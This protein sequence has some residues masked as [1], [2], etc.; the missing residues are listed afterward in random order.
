MGSPNFNTSDDILLNLA[1]FETA[2]QDEDY[3]YELNDTRKEIE[4]ALNQLRDLDFY[5]VQIESGYHEGFQIML[6]SD[7]PSEYVAECVLDFEKYKE[8]YKPN[9]YAFVMEDLQ[10]SKPYMVNVTKQ[11]LQRTIDAE[12]KYIH[13]ELLRIAEEHGLGEVHGKTWTSHVGEILSKPL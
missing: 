10:F 6:V 11:N 9:G 13:N 1:T 5:K 3:T 4:T 7:M 8:A 12:Y 2:S